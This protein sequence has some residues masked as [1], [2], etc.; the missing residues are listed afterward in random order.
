MLPSNIDVV[1]TAE[2]NLGHVD[3]DGTQL[4]QVFMNLAINARDAMPHGGRLSLMARRQRKYDSNVTPEGCIEQVEII[5]MD[6]GFGI[7]PDII[8]KIF[9]PFFTTKDHEKGTGLGS[10]MSFSIIQAHQ[11]R[12]YVTSSL[13]EG[14]TFK[15]TLPLRTA[16]VHMTK[17]APLINDEAGSGMILIADDDEMVRI[18]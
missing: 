10:S 8:D 7:P 9:H 16:E 4:Q 2:H 3:G 12:M 11:G 6:N 14:T 15:I 1:L 13:N 5:V 17:E 18:C